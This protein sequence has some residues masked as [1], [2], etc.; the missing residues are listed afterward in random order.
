M[1]NK[2]LNRNEEASH[3]NS[4]VYGKH[5]KPPNQCKHKYVEYMLIRKRPS[6][7]IK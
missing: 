2:Y 4:E 5:D 6:E 3:F 7:K 1:T